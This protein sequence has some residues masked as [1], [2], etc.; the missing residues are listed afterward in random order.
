[1]NVKSGQIFLT[2]CQKDKYIL[3]PL[4]GIFGGCLRTMGSKKIDA[5]R[6]QVYRKNELIN[7]IDNYFNLY[8]LRSEKNKRL[9]LIKDFYLLRP[10]RESKDIIKLNK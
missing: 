6:H 2:V 8:P 3:E 5:F 4:V 9:L 1:M 7:L 10:D